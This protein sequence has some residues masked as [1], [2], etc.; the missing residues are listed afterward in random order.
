MMRR[1]SA[2]RPPSAAPWPTKPWNIFW[3]DIGSQRE[4]LARPPQEIDAVIESS[5]NAALD[6]GLSRRQRNTS[7]ERSRA[8]EQDRLQDLLSE[9]LLWKER[10]PDFT[11]VEREAQRSRRRRRAAGIEGRP[12]RSHADGKYV[13][14]D[15]KTSDKLDVKDWDGDRPDAPQLRSMP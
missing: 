15:Y 9:W 13:V 6:S 14:L 3:R 4:L 7:L 10:R 5:V 2:Y 1:T 11:V 8:L 12:H